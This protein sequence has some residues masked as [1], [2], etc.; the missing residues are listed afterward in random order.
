MGHYITTTIKPFFSQYRSNQSH[1]I[2]SRD[3][4]CPMA[5]R[6]IETERTETDG[7]Q[8]DGVRGLHAILLI[9]LLQAR[10]SKV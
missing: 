2:P 7:L 3:H 9:V 5:S 10:F 4:D 8:I 1:E 6:H